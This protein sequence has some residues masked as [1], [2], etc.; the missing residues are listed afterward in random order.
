[1]PQPISFD[2]EF[3]SFF[4]KVAE[5]YN[6]KNDIEIVKLTRNYKFNSEYK[7]Y[8]IPSIR[9]LKKFYNKYNNS[10]STTEQEWEW[11]NE[12]IW[13]V[14]VIDK[15]ISIDGGLISV[16]YKTSKYPNKARHLFQ[17][18]MYN[19]ILSKKLSLESKQIKSIIYYPRPDTEEKF[20]FSNKEIALFERD[21][22]NKIN[23]IE[24]TTTFKPEIG[25]H[26]KWCEY[27]NTS[28][29]PKTKE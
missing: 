19:L 22:R 1:M 27:K 8:I 24:N 18:R 9:N 15:L 3:G 2:S 17:M 12:S 4:H 13:L 28:H 6:G 21:L 11:K 29:C 26:C 16:D 25:Y 7:K 20:L 23:E 14:G 5:I 10:D